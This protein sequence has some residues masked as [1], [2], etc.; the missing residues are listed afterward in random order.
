M[1]SSAQELTLPSD[2]ISVGTGF[3]A[4]VGGIVRLDLLHR[5]DDHNFVKM[6]VGTVALISGLYLSYGRRFSADPD[7]SWYALGGLDNNLIAAFGDTLFVPGVHGG[8]GREWYTSGGWRL[9][10]GLALGLP[11]VGGFTFEVGR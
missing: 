2:H 1:G 5:F 8:F 7:A 9:A 3:P 4:P 11:W 6:G 10:F